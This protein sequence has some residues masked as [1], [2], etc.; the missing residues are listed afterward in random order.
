MTQMRAD[1]FTSIQQRTSGY[2]FTV[3]VTQQNT[4]VFV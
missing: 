4:V 2:A 3:W 1:H